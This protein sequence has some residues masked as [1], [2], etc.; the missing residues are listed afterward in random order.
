VNVTPPI[1]S[2]ALRGLVEVFAATAKP[3]VP[4]PLPEA[5]LVT[6]SQA[7]LLA[8]VHAHPTSVVTATLDVALADV[9]ENDAAPSEVVQAPAWNWFDTPLTVA[10]PGPEADTRVSYSCPGVSDTVSLERN[11]ARILPSA[12]GDGFPRLRV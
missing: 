9:A 7:A 11:S 5:P 12:S 2:A 3:T 10:P 8:A 1:V 6:V 4:G